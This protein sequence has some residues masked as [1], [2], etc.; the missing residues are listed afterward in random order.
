MLLGEGGLVAMDIAGLSVAQANYNLRFE[1]SLAMTNQAKKLSEQVGEQFIEMLEKST[2]PHP[3]L[4]Q[5]IDTK[6]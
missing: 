6:G 2:V 5:S 3:T 4:G 1:A